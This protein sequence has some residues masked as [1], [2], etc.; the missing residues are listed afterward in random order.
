MAAT[1]HEIN[2]LADVH[3][4]GSIARS[5]I[6]SQ[7]PQTCADGLHV[8]GVAE[9]EAREPRENCRAT[10]GI[11]QRREPTRKLCRLAHLEHALV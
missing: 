7:I 10:D 4:V 8:A 2:L 1:E 9:S 5:Y 6:D 3:V 11:E